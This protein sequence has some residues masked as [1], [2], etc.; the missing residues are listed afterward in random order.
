MFNNKFKSRDVPLMMANN[1]GVARVQYYQS[2][3]S[4]PSSTYLVSSTDRR[5]DSPHRNEIHDPRSYTILSRHKIVIV[6]LVS[7]NENVYLVVTILNQIIIFL[8]FW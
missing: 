6:Q 3:T 1:V 5:V 4:P 7:Y 8:T 2:A